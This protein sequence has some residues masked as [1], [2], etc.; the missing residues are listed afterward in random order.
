[1]QILNSFQLVYCKN[2]FN[3]NNCFEA[4][5]NGTKSECFKL[6]QESVIIF[7]ITEKYKPCEN[8]KRMCDVYGESC[9]CKQNVYKCVKGGFATK[10]PEWKHTDSEAKKQFRTLLSVKTPSE[11]GRTHDVI[12]SK[13][14]RLFLLCLLR[15]NPTYLL[16]DLLH[17]CNV[18]NKYN[19]MV[20]LLKY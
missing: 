11:Y 16:S 6:E 4:I 17:V 8:F 14:V 10:I 12:S 18:N 9:F 13:K 7:F 2:N 15:Q 3:Q 1:M 19:L 20:F 5:K